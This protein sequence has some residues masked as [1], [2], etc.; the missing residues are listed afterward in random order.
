M[1]RHIQTILIALITGAIIFAA[2]YIYSDN[3]QKASQATQLEL[4]TSQVIE[5]RADV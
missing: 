5:L 2:N 1:E 4:L 3:S